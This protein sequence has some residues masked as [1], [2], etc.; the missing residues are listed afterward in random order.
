MSNYNHRCSGGDNRGHVSAEAI[1]RA[2]HGWDDRET[3]ETSNTP[4]TTKVKEEE[5]SS[6]F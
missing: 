5:L 2:K 1:E 4:A 6:H 3:V